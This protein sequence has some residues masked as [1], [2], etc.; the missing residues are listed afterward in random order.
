[1]L[2]RALGISALRFQWLACSGAKSKEILEQAKKLDNDMDLV[3][4]T[5]GGND[6]CLVRTA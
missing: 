6:L 1:M 4:L 5:A 2:E 3:V